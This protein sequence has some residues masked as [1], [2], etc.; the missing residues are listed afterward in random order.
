M[1]SLA[2]AMCSLTTA[3]IALGTGAVAFSARMRSAR[4]SDEKSLPPVTVL[5]PLCGSD[6][7]LRENLESFFLQDYPVYEIVF[8]VERADDPA[9]AV[10]DALMSAHPSVAALVVIQSSTTG[11]NPKVRNLRGMLPRAS[12]DLVLVSDSNV[13][14]P[15]DYLRGMAAEMIYDPGVGLV[16]SVFAGTGGGSLGGDLECVEL[17]GF[18]AAGAA[19]PTLFGDA[20]VIGKSMLFS[21]REL[22][23]L[24]GLERVADVLAEDYV[25]GKLFQ[26]AGRRV[27]IARTVIENVIGPMSPRAF[28]DRH[29]RWSMLR[30]RLRPLAFLLEPMTSPLFMLPFAWAAMGAWALL[31]TA[32][33]LALRDVAGWFLLRGPIGFTTPLRLSLLRE[34][35]AIGIWFAT[36]FS[37]HV[38]WR[39][40]RLRVSTGTLLIPD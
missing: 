5:K 2:L 40:H 33:L 19:L 7:S 8:G 10:V 12:H 39:G 22:S 13:R 21:R 23:E 18:C 37:R 30:F 4:V 15:P 9:L 31:W 34:V 17:S 25:L 1:S 3:W 16:T 14:V 28:I 20:A 27:V 36:P 38:S 6:P 32:T 26:A 35:A 11:H 29:L 24:G